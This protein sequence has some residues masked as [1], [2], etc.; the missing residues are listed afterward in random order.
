MQALTSPVAVAIRSSAAWRPMHLDDQGVHWYA[1]TP[2]S[3][4]SFDGAWCLPGCLM[5]GT[6]PKLPFSGLLFQECVE[7]I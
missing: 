7:L 6:A 3:L 4:S 5:R 2:L 1:P